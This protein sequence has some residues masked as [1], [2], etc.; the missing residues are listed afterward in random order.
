MRAE[1][2]VGSLQLF[3]GFGGAGPQVVCAHMCVHV[4]CVCVCMHMCVCIYGMCM[5]MCMCV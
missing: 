3:T 1:F 5:N 2:L 4:V